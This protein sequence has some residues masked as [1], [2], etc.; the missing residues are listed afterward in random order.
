MMF[1]EKDKAKDPTAPGRMS[2]KADESITKEVEAEAQ[3][4]NATVNANGVEAGV[5]TGVATVASASHRVNS[6]ATEARIET[7]VKRDAPAIRNRALTNHV[8]SL[9]VHNHLI[10]IGPTQ[11]ASVA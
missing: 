9:S 3:P 6:A 4:E 8:V 1:K 11:K 10:E 5:G 7:V 2:E